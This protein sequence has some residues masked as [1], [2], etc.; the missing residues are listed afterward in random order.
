[1]QAI[2]LQLPGDDLKWIIHQR[3]QTQGKDQHD[4]C[5]NGVTLYIKPITP[6]YFKEQSMNQIQL[7]GMG[8]QKAE[9]YIIKPDFQCQQE[10]KSNEADNGQR[11]PDEAD[12]A[13]QHFLY[14]NMF[15]QQQ[16]FDLIKDPDGLGEKV[17]EGEGRRQQQGIIPFAGEGQDLFLK[18]GHQDADKKQ[19]AGIKPPFALEP[20]NAGPFHHAVGREG[21]LEDPKQQ[22]TDGGFPD[23]AEG[24]KEHKIKQGDYDN[25]P[26]LGINQPDAA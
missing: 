3:S 21:N 7:K 18:L 25:I 1:M 24:E 2:L 6:E 15:V 13:F 20:V 17:K 19:A 10:N 8:P 4:R 22:K 9:E 5:I 11:L 14:K 26:G 16:W 23:I 12:P